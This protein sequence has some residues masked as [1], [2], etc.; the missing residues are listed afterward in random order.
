LRKKWRED[1]V[2][3]LRVANELGYRE[4]HPDELR[5]LRPFRCLKGTKS[6]EDLIAELT[7]A[8]QATVTSVGKSSAVAE[9]SRPS[10]P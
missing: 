8:R 9:G 6:F 4:K 10:S 2:K 1:A 3:Y 7:T 5:E